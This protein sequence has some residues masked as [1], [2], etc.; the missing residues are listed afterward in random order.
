MSET[1]VL[2]VV[3]D[4]H[5]NSTIGLCPPYVEL[6]DGGHYRS[7]KAQR[8]LWRNWK[9][10]VDR[11]QQTAERENGRVITVFNGDIND[12]DHHDTPQI[13]SRNE[14]TQLKIAVESARPLVDISEKVFVV[15]GT[16]VHVGKS[17]SMEE[18][19][20]ADI[21]A[22]QNPETDAF[23][24]W[25]LKLTAAG[26]SLDIAH[27]ASMGRLPWTRS[28]SA[29]K[30]AAVTMF[31]YMNRN[32]KPPDLVIR[33]HQHR[34]SDSWDAY[35]TRAIQLPAWQ[36][37]T[38]YVHRLNPGALADVGGLIIVCRDGSYTVDK[39]AYVP[40]PAKAVKA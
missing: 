5:T 25:H 36:L 38:A 15:R 3:S 32:E 18:T 33:S 29:N 12:G 4:L 21:G 27:H 35:R 11:V 17:G 2:A 1:V 30:L 10:Y 40:T 26:V 14:A 19:F 34:W 8:W 31:E 6:D 23:S 39:C 20:A 22:V 7:S 28:A 9:A 16:E 24:W 37:A 13:I